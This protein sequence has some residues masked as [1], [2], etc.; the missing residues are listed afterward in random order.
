MTRLY[1]RIKIPQKTFVAI[2][3][4][5]LIKGNSYEAKQSTLFYI[6]V[7]LFGL[8]RAQKIIGFELCPSN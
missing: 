3:R 2:W 6:F 1:P 8:D 7:H 4:P 5:K